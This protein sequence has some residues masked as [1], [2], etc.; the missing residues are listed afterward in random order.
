MKKIT[1][2]KT[3]FVYLFPE[4][5]HPLEDEVVYERIVK[6]C[7]VNAPIN[8]GKMIDYSIIRIILADNPI[9]QSEYFL[10][11]L[12]WD[13][14]LDLLSLD[15][16]VKKDEFTDQD[17]MNSIKTFVTEITCLDCNS[18]Y[19]ALVVPTGDSYVSSPNLI[20]EKIKCRKYCS[21]PN[22]LQSLKQLVVKIL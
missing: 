17:F 2:E 10:Y 18:V 16:R 4:D 7:S 15:D 1:V 13:D 11:Y 14:N 19:I 3:N 5:Y 20:D 6:K 8:S 9:R 22:C 21:C 12:Y